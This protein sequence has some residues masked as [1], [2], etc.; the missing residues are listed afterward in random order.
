MDF[1]RDK[2]Q[3][4]QRREAERGLPTDPRVGDHVGDHRYGADDARS[5]T[6]HFS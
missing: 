6:T 5:L 3:A 1:G 4:E 2:R